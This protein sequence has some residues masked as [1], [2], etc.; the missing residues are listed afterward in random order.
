MRMP[1][2][3]LRRPTNISLNEAHLAEA[4]ALGINVS[5]ACERGLVQEIQAVRAE[6]WREENRAALESYN[7]FVEERGLPLEKLRLF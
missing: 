6:R 5:Q 7:Q 4:R 3:P 2:K 1:L